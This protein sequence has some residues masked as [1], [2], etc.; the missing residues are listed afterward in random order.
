MTASPQ[1]LTLMLYDGAIK[2][3]NQAVQAI[4]V[5]NSKLAHEKIIRVEDIILEFM[6]S[7][8][9]NYEVA[10]NM[11]LMYDYIYHRLVDANVKKDASVVEEVIGYLREFRDSW[12]QAMDLAK[13]PKPN[14][15]STNGMYEQRAL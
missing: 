6:A 15:E 2:F 11:E 3:A 12:K 1:E 9:H 5:E 10:T 13:N 8:D 7:L 4:K 14:Q